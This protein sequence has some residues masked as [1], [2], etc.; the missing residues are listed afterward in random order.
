MKGLRRNGG[1]TL[2]E[3]LVALVVLSVGL[4]GLAGLQ[5]ATVR[6]A[7]NG[8]LRSQVVIQERAIL[9]RMRANRAQA[10]GHGYDTSFGASAPTTT[11]TS[12]CSAS[13]MASADKGAWLN[14]LRR[15]PNGDGQIS[16][17][18]GAAVIE[19]R[20]TDSRQSGALMT[21]RMATEL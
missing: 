18:A 2:I 11:C 19:V 6:N 21:F 20:W 12:T 7:Y 16:T 5:A 10:L 3:L 13:D 17:L 1:F 15:L 8:L 14:A 9:D 4:L